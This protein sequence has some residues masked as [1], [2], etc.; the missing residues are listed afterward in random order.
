MPVVID[1]L[2]SNFEVR[3]E[4]KLKKLIIAEIKA[5]LAQLKHSSKDAD[6]DGE[7]KERRSDPEP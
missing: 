5:A 7:V 2:T 3:D 6:D 4:A 1:E